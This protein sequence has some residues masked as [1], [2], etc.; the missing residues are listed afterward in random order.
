MKYT[1]LAAFVLLVLP[2][3]LSASTSFDSWTPLL[4]SSKKIRIMVKSP[5]EEANERCKGV[6]GHLLYFSDE[7]ELRSLVQEINDL[8]PDLK[9][10]LWF[11]ARKYIGTWHSSYPWRWTSGG[12]FYPERHNLTRTFLNDPRPDLCAEIRIFK[13]QPTKEQPIT[14]GYEIGF[15][16]CAK[17]RMAICQARINPYE[18]M[19]I[20]SMVLSG[21]LFL[22]L[23]GGIIWW[24]RL[25]RFG[26]NYKPEKAPPE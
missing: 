7:D 8:F 19:A 15:E 16:D 20:T 11:G 18:A 14:V 9:E 5:F 1:F 4:S 21:L 22:L 26:R 3:H 2:S 6:H 25:W 24:L 23:I 13:R 12:A 17:V 10:E